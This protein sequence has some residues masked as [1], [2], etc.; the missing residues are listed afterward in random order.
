MSKRWVQRPPGSTWGDWGDE[1]ELGRLNLLMPEKVKEGMAEVKAGITFCLSLP[2]DLPGRHPLPRRL[3]PTLSPADAEGTFFNVQHSEMANDARYVDVYCDDQATISLQYS[4][5]WDAFAHVGAKFDIDGDGVD[6]A[7]YYNGFRAGTDVVGPTPDASGDRRNHTSFA[8]HTGIEH[9]AY[10]GV[11]GRGVLI[12]L[13]RHFGEESR[14][15]DYETLRQVM[16]EDGVVVEPGDMVLIHTG[17]TTAILEMG[18]DT[19][20]DRL[21]SICPALD[22]QDERLLQWVTES[23]LAALA[24]DNY[25]IEG[26]SREQSGTHTR[27]F[28]PLHNLCLFKLGVHLGQFWYLHELATWLR[29]NGRSRFLLT[30][31]PLRLPGAIASPVTPIATV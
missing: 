18:L 25:S 22:S 4:T 30:A 10:K 2:L 7:V 15:V 3:A 13:A 21:G 9:M 19:D 12:D 31:A 24:A 5:H 29:E 11:Q 6:E 28:I 14:L 26:I 23:Q 20:L 27:P 8:R 16:D 17:W 1:D